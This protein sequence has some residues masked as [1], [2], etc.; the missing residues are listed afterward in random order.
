MPVKPGIPIRCERC[1]RVRGDVQPFE[2]RDHPAKLPGERFGMCRTCAD[3]LRLLADRRYVREGRQLLRNRKRG[4]SHLTPIGDV[5]AGFRGEGEKEMASETAVA[6]IDVEAR[7]LTTMRNPPEAVLLEAKRAA[8]AL[9]D[10]VAQKPNKV[11][12]NGEQYL[13]FEDWQTLGR[14]YGITA[15]EDGDPTFVNMD[16]VKGFKASAVALMNGEV[17]SRAT[18]Y[19]LSDEEKWGTRTKY[20]YAYVKKSGGHSVEDPG[21]DEL[22]WEENPNKP[23]SKRPRKERIKVGD[24]QVPLFQLASMAQTRAA[25]KVHRNVLSW[26]VVLAGYRPTPAEEI[27]NDTERVEQAKAEPKPNGKPKRG[28]AAP[29]TPGVEAEQ[30]REPG[31]EQPPS[32]TP[33]CPFCGSINVIP[34][35]KAP[36]WRMCQEDEC[37]KGSRISGASSS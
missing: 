5:F 16:G 9:R 18:A 34:D 10:V 6:V 23:G 11:M 36:G 33:A 27:E 7:A 4:Y 28:P 31:D 32:E 2:W 15:K 37:R 17:I 30:K 22:I 25:A 20:A 21:K 8:Q 12:M 1:G 29:P 19:C 35:P 14:F 3:L 24:E 13:E 26:I